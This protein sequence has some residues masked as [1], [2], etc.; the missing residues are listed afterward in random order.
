MI[1]T[2]D[3]L[4]NLSLPK[5]PQCIMTGESITEEQAMEIIRRT[6]RFFYHPWVF[7]QSEQWDRKVLN[8]TKCPVSQDYADYDKYSEDWEDW[9]SKWRYIPLEYLNNDYIS[10]PMAHGTQGWCH[11]DGTIGYFYNIGKWPEVEEVY[12]DLC[13]IG[14]NFRF[15]QLELTLMSDE[16]CEENHPVV[17]MILRDGKVELVDP[18]EV[19]VHKKYNRIV[20]APK[21]N[22]D[23]IREIITKGYNSDIDEDILRTWGKMIS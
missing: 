6:D 2:F 23:A 10:S 21:D 20:E 1:R 13:T 5:W 16:Y 15:L 17:S 19:D 3:Q 7:R 8:L 22:M 18:D 12:K 14:E 4:M 9:C 11:L